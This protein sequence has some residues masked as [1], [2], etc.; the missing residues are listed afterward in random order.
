MTGG[1]TMIITVI[2]GVLYLP[3]YILAKLT[4]MYMK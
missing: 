2:L 4:K 3:V 1:E